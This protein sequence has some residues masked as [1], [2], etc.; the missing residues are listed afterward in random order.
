[1]NQID[2]SVNNSSASSEPTKMSQS[3]TVQFTRTVC[4][5]AFI[6]LGLLT[7]LSFAMCFVVSWQSWG[8]SAVGALLGLFPASVSWWLSR[9]TTQY[10]LA[11]WIISLSSVLI[12]TLLYWQSPFFGIYLIFLFVLT[13]IRVMLGRTQ[14]FLSFGI[15]LLNT[16]A[17]AVLNHNSFYAPDGQEVKVGFDTLALWW[18]V[19]GG[20]L[21]LTSLLYD[22]V[23]HDN[24]TLQFQALELRQ[25]LDEL[26]QRQTSSENVSRQ[27]LAMG[28]EL[29]QISK[30]QLVSSQQQLTALT[31]VASLVAQIANSAGS[32]EEQTSL[33]KENIEKINEST[34]KVQTNSEKA[35]AAGNGGQSAI[36]STL[37]ATQKV[38][39]QYHFLWQ[40]LAQLQQY[41]A[42]IGT[43]VA[44]I[45]AISREIHLL[46]LNAALEAAGAGGYGE[47]FLVV[48]GEVRNLAQRS[49][50][51][52]VEVGDILG[53]IE[54]G[55]NQVAQSAEAAQSEVEITLKATGESDKAIRL[56]LEA[57]QQ[58]VQEVIQTGQLASAIARQIVSVSAAT[59]QQVSATSQSAHNVQEI[60]AVAAQNSKVSNQLNQSATHLEQVSARLLSSLIIKP[61][62][63]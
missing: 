62:Q 7:L 3:Y 46:S 12:A 19:M 1:M 34:L 5:L 32:I 23:Q 16:V 11:A 45:N 31:E 30:Q 58:N 29:S 60:K 48:A 4:L 52:S 40:N 13:T 59:F 26:K 51:A 17:Y 6:L 55:I 36:H 38:S 39:Q 10:R 9:Y 47:R 21:W 43:I 18:V 50:Q 2:Q 54:E 25:A 63:A 24:R 44:T 37:L 28:A 56:L 49:Q 15:L 8:S 22:R 33:V 61:D 41:Q 57:L 35:L 20:V 27:V 53:K 42:Q 14:A